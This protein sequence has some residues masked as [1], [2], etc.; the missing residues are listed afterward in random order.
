[1]VAADWRRQGQL[2]FQ[3]YPS[4]VHSLARHAFREGAKRV[5]PRCHFRF[6]WIG[7]H[8]L[9]EFALQ[10]AGNLHRRRLRYE[11]IEPTIMP[12]PLY[13]PRPAESGL[14]LCKAS[15]I[16]YASWKSKPVSRVGSIFL[17]PAYMRHTN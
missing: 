9:N 17:K 14:L 5:R 16:A 4:L 2:I 12:V 10:D 15:A 13:S 11:C 3:Y 7:G 6:L 1:V 8:R